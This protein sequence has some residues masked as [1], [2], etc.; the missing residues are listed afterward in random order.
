MSE[1]SIQP[2]PRYVV[3][4]CQ[5]CNGHIEFDANAFAEENS[6][7]PCPHCSLET[8]IFIPIAQAEIVTTQLPAFVAAPNAV[9]RED[10]FCGEVA[11]HETETSRG[12]LL[13]CDGRDT[14]QQLISYTPG[15]KP[16]TTDQAA[17]N[18]GIMIAKC[19]CE[20]CDKAIQ[21]DANKLT[22]ENRI[23]PCPHCGWKTSLYK[24]AIFKP[25]ILTTIN[26]TTIIIEA[27]GNHKKYVHQLCE[28]G[29]VGLQIDHTRKEV[30]AIEYDNIPMLECTRIGRVNHC[31][32]EV[33]EGFYCWY[34]RHAE[35]KARLNE[36]RW[37]IVE[38]GQI[39]I[40]GERFGYDCF[41]LLRRI[42]PD[43]SEYKINSKRERWYRDSPLKDGGTRG[44]SGSLPAH[45]SAPNKN[46]IPP[47]CEL[48]I[49]P[50]PQ[51]PQKVTLTKAQCETPLAKQLI[52]LLVGIEK[53]GFGT[54]AGVRRLNEW[55]ESKA[56]F[57][58]PA[59]SFLLDVSR[60][61]LSCGNITPENAAKMQNAIVRVLPR[62]IQIAEINVEEFSEKLP[63]RKSILKRI[64]ERGGNPWPGITRA[65]AHALEEKL[66]PK[67]MLYRIRELGGKPPRGITEAEACELKDDL[68]YQPTKKQ[69]EYIRALGVRPPPDL[70][71]FTAI[72]LIDKLLHSVKA[73]ERQLQ[74]IHE[75]GGNSSADLTHAAAAEAI[76]QLLARQQ[77][78]P[79]QMMLLRFWNKTD[80]MKASKNEVA[81]WLDQFYDEDPRR[82]EAWEAFKL[83]TGD[84]GSQHDPSCVPIG[85]GESYL[86]RL[87]QPI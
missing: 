48:K 22:D 39:N 75:L 87:N 81:T 78:T 82:K 23:V 74:Y 5:H 63:A 57:E 77:P 34:V 12:K 83:E 73:T 46:I 32:F 50:P 55:L 24:P 21:F 69:L 66:P 15:D 25:A 33:P 11:I 29:A 86:S 20:R 40:L 19:L 84:D 54:D 13:P 47:V 59:V 6:V 76:K 43:W 44:L 41:G 72:E 9:R 3:C 71:R 70:T 49:K 18:A 31:E 30:T 68:Y 85:V 4:N 26:L 60:D 79:R 28:V 61:V 10:F 64:R 65:E 42:F 14:R 17:K 35:I 7:V 1:P 8:K 27:V 16:V 56:D 37:F 53:E 67:W 80:L 36:Y 52:G 45:F 2:S 62:D 38:N 51:I 58:I